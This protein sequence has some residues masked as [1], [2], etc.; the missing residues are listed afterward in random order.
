MPRKCNYKRYK[1]QEP[2]TRT[3]MNTWAGVYAPLGTVSM[4]DIRLPA[5]DKNRIV[6]NHEFGVFEQ[7]CRYDIL[8]GG[9][10]LAKVGMNL[11][12]KNLEVEWLGNTILIESTNQ[13][14][15]PSV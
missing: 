1:N 12:Y 10:F 4:E 13:L 3:M 11:D 15:W 14:K 9:D 6:D 8:L 7:E 5:F 2:K